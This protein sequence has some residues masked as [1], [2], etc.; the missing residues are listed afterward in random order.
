MPLYLVFW[1]ENA[2]NQLHSH[3]IADAKYVD[4]KKEETKNNA[5]DSLKQKSKIWWHFWRE[6]GIIMCQL[7]SSYAADPVQRSLVTILT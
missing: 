5:N 6:L 2:F 4:V 7:F 1:E 3:F